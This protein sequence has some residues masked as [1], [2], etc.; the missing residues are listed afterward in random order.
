[1]LMNLTALLFV[2]GAFVSTGH[3]TCEDIADPQYPNLCHEILQSL[4]QALINDKGNIYRSRKAFF[5]ASNANPV[6]LR[7]KYNITFAENITEDLLPFCSGDNSSMETAIP[8]NQMTIIHGWT[9]TGLYLLIE[10]L[11]LTYAQ[12]TLPLAI[13]HWIHGVRERKT[14]RRTNPE[15]ETF[16]WDGFG[17]LP[18]LLISLHIS[19]LP[20][21]PSEKVF[22]STIEDLTTHVCINQL[23]QL[24][25]NIKL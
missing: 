5:Y 11:V 12:M 19:S 24:H 9:S 14:N 16:L 22:D 3:C 6:L 8:I 13:L 7:V 2:I 18:T 1:M 25:N 21:I 15:V 20:C 23:S 10:P 17:D 4:E